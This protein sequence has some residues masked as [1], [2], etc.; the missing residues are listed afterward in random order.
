MLYFLNWLK[1]RGVYLKVVAVRTTNEK[2]DLFYDAEKVFNATKT[3]DR[4][5]GDINMAIGDPR[6]G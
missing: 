1:E 2:N 6:Q 5:A 3:Y 4:P